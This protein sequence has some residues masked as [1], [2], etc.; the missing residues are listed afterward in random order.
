MWLSVTAQES[1]TEHCA[2]V[3]SLSI[4]RVCIP[5]WEPTD[6]ST[7]L[8]PQELVVSGPSKGD[9]ASRNV[10]EKLDQNS[11]L[12]SRGCQNVLPRWSDSEADVPREQLACVCGNC[13]LGVACASPRAAVGIHA[14]VG[15]C[16]RAYSS[17]RAEG[18][19]C[20]PPVRRSEVS[21]RT[22][23]ASASIRSAAERWGSGGSSG[24]CLRRARGRRGWCGAS[25]ATRRCR[26]LMINRDEA[27]S[28][29][30]PPTGGLQR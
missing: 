25:S 7:G 20:P 22:A 2:E 10:I 5:P 16:A 14:M 30:H 4:D 18:S 3:G 26:G 9:G 29:W 1:V 11:P 6:P 21:K 28:Q 24:R 15:L 13:L 12:L 27:T 19:D 23:C 8:V 17:S